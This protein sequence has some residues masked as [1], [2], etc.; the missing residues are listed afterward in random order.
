[1]AL[2]KKKRKLTKN[3]SVQQGIQNFQIKFDMKLK[4]CLLKSAKIFFLIRL[5]AYGLNA[6][7]SAAAIDLLG[8]C[9]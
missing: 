7:W 4:R 2:W 6:C 8:T 1:M 9:W 5:I 3:K